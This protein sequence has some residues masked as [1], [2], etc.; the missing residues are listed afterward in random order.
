MSYVVAGRKIA[1]EYLALATIG[2]IGGITAFQ[3]R[4]S[5]KPKAKPIQELSATGS[6]E[7]ED[8]IRNFVAEAEKEDSKKHH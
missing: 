6:K 4:G 5:S 8:F 1:T 7:E 3:M 2:A